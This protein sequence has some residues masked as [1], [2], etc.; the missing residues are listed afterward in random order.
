MSHRSERKVR[1]ANERGDVFASQSLGALL[2]VGSGGALCGP[3]TNRPD[4]ERSIGWA[5]GL[6]LGN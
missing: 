5:V 6:R 4:A 2:G 3:G 1:A